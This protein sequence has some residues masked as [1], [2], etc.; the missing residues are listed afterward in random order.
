MPCTERG[1]PPDERGMALAA[2]VF[3]LAVMG[4]L[5]AGN[6]MA[7]WIEHQSGRNTLFAAQAAEAAEAELREALVLVPAGGLS[8]LSI[9]GPAHSLGAV[10]FGGIT[11]EREVARLTEGLFL[12]RVRASRLDAGGMPLATRALGLLVKP[13]SDSMGPSSVVPLTQRPWVQLY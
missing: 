8:A 3:A 9:G 13:A 7:G 11:V 6:F 2:A 12:L 10:S 1:V 4:G 5:V